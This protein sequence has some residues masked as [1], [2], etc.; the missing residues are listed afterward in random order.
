MVAH[1]WLSALEPW[2]IVSFYELLLTTSYPSLTLHLN[3]FWNN[4]CMQGMTWVFV[5]YCKSEWTWMTWP[6]ILVW[7]QWNA[8]TSCTHQSKLFFCSGTFIATKTRLWMDIYIQV[9]SVHFHFF[10]HD[11]CPKKLEAWTWTLHLNVCTCLYLFIWGAFSWVPFILVFPFFS[12]PRMWSF[13]AMTNVLDCQCK[14]HIKCTFTQSLNA[15]I[16]NFCCCF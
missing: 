9:L 11:M 8:C 7:Q 13:D 10:V 14:A 15:H 6:Y 2:S 16:Y 1:E 4:N 3:Y 5:N 12:F